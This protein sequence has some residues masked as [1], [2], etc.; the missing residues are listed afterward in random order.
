MNFR[1]KIRLFLALFFC[2]PLLLAQTTKPVIVVHGG[3]GNIVSGR[4]SAQEEAAYREALSLA[5]KTGYRALLD[6]KT[7]LDAVQISIQVL[8]ENPLFNAGVGA[9]LNADGKVEL[10]ASIMCGKTY[11]AGAVAGVNKIKSPILAARTVM[12]KSAH[13]MMVGQGAHDFAAKEKLPLVKPS[14]FVQPKSIESL[15]KAQQAEKDKAFWLTKNDEFKFGTVGALA[16]DQ[17]GNLAAGTSTGGMTNKKYGR[18]GDSPIIGAGTYADNLGCAV[19]ATGHGEYFIRAVAAFQANAFVR[20]QGL[21][22]Q[23]AGERVIE[24][25]GAMGG[26]GGLI[27]LN[28]QGEIA[29]PFNTAG[30]FRGAIDAQGNIEILFYGESK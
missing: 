2:A 25:I 20:M 26:K 13:V 28:A 29:M 18:V 5:L 3:A 22:L 30:M 21:S 19:S 1:L 15:K 4:F 27:L 8:E 6:G 11:Q 7:S 9:V 12:E 24:N 14:Y 16:L 17:Y 23:K 10:D